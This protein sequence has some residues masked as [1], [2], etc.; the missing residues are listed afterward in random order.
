MS[1]SPLRFFASDFHSP[2]PF[3]LPSAASLSP[4]CFLAPD[5]SLPSEPASLSAV[6]SPPPEAHLAVSFFV[7][8]LPTAAALTSDTLL[9]PLLFAFA[10]HLTQ[11]AFVSCVFAVPSTP[12]LPATVSL[13]V[14]LAFPPSLGAMRLPSPNS[15]LSSQTSFFLALVFPSLYSLSLLLRL[16]EHSFHFLFRSRSFVLNCQL[17]GQ[18]S[19]VKLRC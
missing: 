10:S 18:A 14:A 4:N 15:Y 11:S 2:L 13:S 16:L 17:V 19:P 7:S 9:S 3:S 5:V 1:S 6:L 8:M 12:L